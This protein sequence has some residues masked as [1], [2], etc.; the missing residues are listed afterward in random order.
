MKE[1]ETLIKKALKYNH[2]IAVCLPNKVNKYGIT[3]HK[4]KKPRDGY[5]Y[6]L[7]L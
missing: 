6:S 5:S 4:N 1:I 3:S 2:T 7:L